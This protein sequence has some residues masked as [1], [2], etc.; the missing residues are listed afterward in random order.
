M[1]N[2]GRRGGVSALAL[3]RCLALG[4]GE[5]SDG[6]AT[7]DFVGCNTRRALHRGPATSSVRRAAMIDDPAEC[8]CGV[9]RPTITSVRDKD[10]YQR[11]GAVIATGKHGLLGARQ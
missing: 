1:K 2:G 8:P 6:E 7:T 5:K 11:I 3:N 4:P 10:R 9:F